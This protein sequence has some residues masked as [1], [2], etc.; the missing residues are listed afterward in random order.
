MACAF[1]WVCVCVYAEN[2]KQKVFWMQSS[3]F[4]TI[5]ASQSTT[6]R[7]T[8]T[9]LPFTFLPSDLFSPTPRCCIWKPYQHLFMK[10][11]GQL[12]IQPRNNWAEFGNVIAI[13]INLTETE[14][15]LR[16]HHSE[17]R[18]SVSIQIEVTGC[19][20]RHLIQTFF[21]FG[22]RNLPTIMSW[23]EAQRP[24]VDGVN[25][26]TSDFVDLTDFANIVIKLNNLLLTE[27]GHK[28]RWHTSAQRD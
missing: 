14:A 19:T 17:V 10:F 23:V 1:A 9:S 27:Q 22:S 26:I 20:F 28:A 21:P 13:T 11:G 3:D 24:G 8:Q 5:L 12:D 18:E 7:Q 2:Q 25:I 16:I 6:D 4:E 15:W